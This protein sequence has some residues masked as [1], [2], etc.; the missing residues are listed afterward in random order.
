MKQHIN[1]ITS[2]CFLL[3]CRLKQVRRILGPEI[4]TSLV[5]GFVTSRLDYCNALLAGLS[6]STIA[7]LQQVQKLRQRLI[8][9]I[10]YHDHITPI[11]R[12]LHWPLVS[13][14]TI[15]KLCVLMHLAHIRCSPAYRTELFT[16]T[17]ELPTR[18][19]LLQEVA[20]NMQCHKQNEHFHSLVQ[21]HGTLLRMILH[22]LSDTGILKKTLKLF[23]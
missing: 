6:K 17:S 3:I 22:N 13:L 14:R 7:P 16:A 5:S 1:I 20:N 21:L 10:G 19:R 12:S 23:F 2:S 8:S 18:R 15:Y 9:E 11:F 4:T